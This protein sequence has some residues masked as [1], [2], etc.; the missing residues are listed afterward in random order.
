MHDRSVPTLSCHL[1]THPF[2]GAWTLVAVLLIAGPLPA[3][4]QVADARSTEA[5][6]TAAQ[7]S[8]G[9]A[10]YRERCAVCHGVEMDDGTAP[11]LKG[12][13]FVRVWG[14][15]ERSLDDLFYILR[16]TMPR[17][18]R[19]AL[20]EDDYIDVLAYVLQ[21][22]G[23]RVGERALS[24][25]AEVLA[26]IRL[27]AHGQVAETDS[28]PA[29]RFI[30]GDRGLEVSGSGP[31]QSELTAAHTNAVDWLYHTHDYS[32]RRYVELEQIRRG[33]ANQLTA[34]CAFQLGGDHTFQAG[35]I[36]YRGVMYV[37]TTRL[38]AALDAATCRALW[39]HEW[40]PRD[41][42]PW[43]NN[44]GV[45]IKDGRV[46]RGTAD[47]Y[48]LALD[49]TDGRLLW[50]SHVAEPV[51]GETITMPPMIY[52]DL[53]LIGPA[54]S[55]NNISGWVGAFRLEDGQPVWKF[56]TVLGASEEGGQAWPNP[57]G[58]PLGGG[59]VWTPLALDVEREELYVAVTNPA[60]DFPAHLRP[61]PNLYTNSLVALDVRSGELRWYAQL[62]PNDSHD[63]DLTQVSPL[64]RTEVK[65]QARDLVA[66]VG[67]DGILRVLD[68]RTHERLYETPVTTQEN[69]D[70]PLTGEGVRVCPGY[71]GG[72]EWNGPAFN[73]RTNMLY[74]N[75][76]DWCTT[77]ALADTVRYVDGELYLGGTVE[78]DE[79]SQGWLTAID[80]STGEVRWRYRS[81]RPMVSA[82]TTTAGELLITGELDGDLI[83]F[84]ARTGGELYRFNT[85][86]P[87]GG[88]I[89]T[90]SVDG[91][92]YIATTSGQASGNF[93]N[94]GA[95]VVFVFALPSGAR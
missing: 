85:G 52:E 50:A 62:V 47:G 59:A 55:E 21:R 18:G 5:L 28:T 39:R 31:T 63:W 83:V 75:A 70:V 4:A 16:T 9:R 93:S 80:A 67:K 88:G 61:G 86:G 37:S 15:A 11:P 10:L 29:P 91:R 58:I 51:L 66:T 53:V 48:L 32:G 34:V 95:P 35:P 78:M 40:E 45:A 17:D 79:E 76:V 56:K 38:T 42:E 94:E 69:V 6:F 64:F 49:A 30:K 77:F 3:P 36:V 82:L 41:A 90:Y 13:D 81:E 89:V 44:R 87:I 23:Y 26:A 92:Q 54:G 2:R 27:E 12:P 68:R 19:G 74:V 57:E 43:P 22:N 71:L 60:P 46:V 65:G 84:D 7:A 8:A 24:A 73:P 1:P 72:V 20:S 25:N 14:R 33:N